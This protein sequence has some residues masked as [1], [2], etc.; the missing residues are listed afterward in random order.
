MNKLAELLEAE[1]LYN[2]IENEE[3]SASSLLSN[4]KTKRGLAGSCSETIKGTLNT[5]NYV[6]ETTYKF[7]TSAGETATCTLNEKKAGVYD[8]SMKISGLSYSKG[9]FYLINEPGEDVSN[10]KNI[11]TFQNATKAS[12]YCSIDDDSSGVSG[13]KKSNSSGGGLSGGAI[14]G[15]VIACVAVVAIVGVVVFAFT[16]GSAFLGGGA[17]TAAGSYANAPTSSV[18]NEIIGNIKH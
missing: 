15:V 5:L 2:F 7:Q 12:P 6:P 11:L 9:G 1:K 16:K 14:A 17:A 4:L 13:S 3:N 8:A 10:S 18:S